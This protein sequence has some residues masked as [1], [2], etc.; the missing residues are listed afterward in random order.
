M[1]AADIG[2]GLVQQLMT[3]VGMQQRQ[4]TDAIARIAAEYIS[5]DELIIG[6]AKDP[7]GLTE[8]GAHG[9]QVSRLAVSRVAIQVPPTTAIG[10]KV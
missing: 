10:N 9:P 2:V 3:A 6:G 4:L 1:N 7:L 5:A 8:L